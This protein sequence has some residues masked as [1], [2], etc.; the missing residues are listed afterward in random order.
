MTD[1]NIRIKGI[2]A[3]IL[4]VDVDLINDDTAIG[5][6]PEWDSVAN[7]KLLQHLEHTFKIEIDVLDALD[8]ED[9]RDFV[10]LVVSYTEKL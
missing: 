1:I 2:I 4:K 8:A 6:L 7:I 9:V 10:H 3:D 5:D